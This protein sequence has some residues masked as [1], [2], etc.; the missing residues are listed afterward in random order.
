MPLSPHCA[1]WVLKWPRTLA[2]TNSGHLPL[3]WVA[4]DL[5][6]TATVRNHSHRFRRLA[7]ESEDH[8][9]LK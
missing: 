8:Q 6:R 5:R 1:G 9:N 2:T 7:P 4:G 3:R